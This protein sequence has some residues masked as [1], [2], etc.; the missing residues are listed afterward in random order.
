MKTNPGFILKPGKRVRM[1][2]TVRARLDKPQNH[3]IWPSLIVAISATLFGHLMFEYSLQLTGW[4]SAQ[5]LTIHLENM[6]LPK[7]PPTMNEQVRGISGGRSMCQIGRWQVVPMT[8]Q[9]I[10]FRIVITPRNLAG[11]VS[12]ESGLYVYVHGTNLCLRPKGTSREPMVGTDDG[13]GASLV[14]GNGHGCLLTQIVRG[15]K[16]VK[17]F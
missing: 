2:A 4:V 11:R 5:G 17:R 9:K 16:C 8:T 7:N 6:D 3:R 13:R 14:G 15:Y 10:S 12:T 1:G